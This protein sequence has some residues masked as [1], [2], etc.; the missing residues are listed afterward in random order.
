METLSRTDTAIL[1]EFGSGSGGNVNNSGY[2]GST[3]STGYT[4][5]TGSTGS[6]GPTGMVFTN[7][8]YKTITSYKISGI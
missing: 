5:Y 2:T 7:K 1:Y 6:T 8:I 3:G 4:G